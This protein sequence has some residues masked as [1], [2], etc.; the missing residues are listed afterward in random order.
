MEEA[1]IKGA[2]WTCDQGKVAMPATCR[3]SGGHSPG[4]RDQ[5]EGVETQNVWRGCGHLAGEQQLRDRSRVW[6][7]HNE[8]KLCWR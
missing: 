3:L 2:P 8:D 5:E 1:E 6:G 4:V 7:Q